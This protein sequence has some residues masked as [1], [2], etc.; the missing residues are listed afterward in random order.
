MDFG[1]IEFRMCDGQRNLKNIKMLAALCQALTYQSY[2]DYKE[3]NT[4][5]IIV[6]AKFYLKR[7]RAAQE[8]GRTRQ[9]I[10]DFR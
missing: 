9:A 4:T 10:K 6:L 7:A 3:N 5:V 2:I 8:I 1:T